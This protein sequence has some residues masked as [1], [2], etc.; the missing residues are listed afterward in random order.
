MS[1]GAYNMVERNFGLYILTIKQ[2]QVKSVKE[3][4][5]FGWYDGA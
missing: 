1:V 4:L 2:G 5:F 3:V